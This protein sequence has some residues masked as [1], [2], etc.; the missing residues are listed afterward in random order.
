[1]MQFSATESAVLASKCQVPPDGLSIY[2]LP[3][4]PTHCVKDP[5]L[6]YSSSFSFQGQAVCQIANSGR[7]NGITVKT[8]HSLT[9]KPMLSKP[10]CGTQL[11][12]CPII[13][14][15]TIKKVQRAFRKRFLGPVS[16]LDYRERCKPLQLNTLWL[17]RGKLKPTILFKHLRLQAHTDENPNRFR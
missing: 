5:D 17:R 13:F 11:E 2:G 8:F 1:M 15:A 9:C 7:A 3:I 10:H 6:Q 16:S 14:S 12:C 4:P